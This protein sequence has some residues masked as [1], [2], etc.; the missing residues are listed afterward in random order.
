MEAP[1]V[2][3][4]TVFPA[5]P[6]FGTCAWCVVVPGRDPYCD[7]YG[8]HRGP[9]LCVRHRKKWLHERSRA[10]RRVTEAPRQS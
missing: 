6:H 9:C 4:W 3:R 1:S 5:G 7:T 2:V 8:H 10:V